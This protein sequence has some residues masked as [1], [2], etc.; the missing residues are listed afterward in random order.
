[1]S[2]VANQE[3]I[4]TMEEKLSSVLTVDELKQTLDT[5]D[6]TLAFYEVNRVVFDDEERDYLLEAY[7]DAVTAQGLSE[8][9]IK[10][11]RYVL[12]KFLNSVGVRSRNISPYHIRQY[13]TSEKARGIG[14]RTLASIRFVFSGYFN[15]LHRDG[16]I[17]K[18]PMVNIGPIRCET[19][20]KEVFSECDLEKMKMGCTTLRDKA[21]VCFLKASGCRVGEVETLTR[22]NVDLATRC[23]VV[24]GKGNKWR[25]VYIDS[26]TAMILDEYLKSRTDD[27]PSLF[28]SLR[29][30]NTW[31]QNG[32]RVMLKK[33]SARTGVT[34]VH[35]HK[36]RRTELTYLHKK[37]MS[38][39]E[40]KLLAGHSKIDTTL[41]YVIINDEQISASY[42]RYA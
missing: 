14:D 40:L 33:L 17:Q 34:H 28:V 19:Q 12:T 26:V 7:F 32:M 42:N 8:K 30:D 18:N 29:G 24:H 3:I 25:K 38:P 10:Q 22:D 27:N 13:I 1:M 23:C 36:F 5:L 21:L 20:L 2:I 11:Y 6:A 41:G 9:T 37:G 39:E 16:L 31:H 4:R 15:W 35:P